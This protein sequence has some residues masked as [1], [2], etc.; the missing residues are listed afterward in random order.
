MRRKPKVIETLEFTQLGLKVDLK[1]EPDNQFS[2][3]VYDRSF[4]DVSA[5]VVKKWVKEQVQTTTKVEWKEMIEIY[6]ME[7]Y[8]LSFRFEGFWLGETSTGG[9]LKCALHAQPE[10]RLAWARVIFPHKKPDG[11]PVK[12]GYGGN[13]TFWVPYTK[14]LVEALGELQD[15]LSTVKLLLSNENFSLDTVKVINALFSSLNEKTPG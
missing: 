12:W 15:N 10:Q 2:A 13:M 7:S 11:F 9:L 4:I 5:N 3:T 1:L 14:E 6:L 8:S